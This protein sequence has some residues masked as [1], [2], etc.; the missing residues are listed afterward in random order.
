MRK[1]VWAAVASLL[2]PSLGRAEVVA[3]FAGRSITKAELEAHMRPK[4]IELDNERY[5]AMRDGL[6]EMVAESLL[7][8]EA[9]ARGV[10]T[11]ALQ[12]QEITDKIAAPTDAEIQKVYD[13]NKEQLDGASL[14]SVKS[15][16]VDFLKQQKLSERQ[17]AFLEGL[18]TKYKAS[19]DLPAPVIEVGTGGRP[20]LGS[21]T[22]AVTIIEFSDY[23]CP[24][25]KKAEETVKK[26][27][28]AYGDK[29]RFVYRDFPL[30]MHSHAR[31][32]AEAAHCAQAQGKFWEYHAKLFASADLGTEKLKS[33]ATEVGLDRA[34]FDVCLDK[35]EF[36]AAV[37]KDV[38]DGSNAGVNGTPAFF[39]NGRMMSGALPLEKFKEVIDAEL[40][41]AGKN[42]PS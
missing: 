25:C 41:R 9:K 31:P 18:K 5:E 3:T 1:V 21:K 29:V 16:I 26:V 19:I 8:E 12:R 22:A 24:F 13:D 11:E 23:E 36:K 40:A 10:S 14:E 30:P 33:M 27:L 38:A 34:K 15:Q 2:L 37:D 32:A 17:Q 20:E 39:I 4:L 42:K 35:Q 7:N 6:E 28:A